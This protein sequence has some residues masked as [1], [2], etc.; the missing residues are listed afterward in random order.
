M[1]V[2]LRS[3]RDDAKAKRKRLNHIEPQ[4]W[5]TQAAQDSLLHG[6]FSPTFIFKKF[7]S[8]CI[9]LQIIQID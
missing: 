2:L 3:H 9:I 8:F 7:L 4:A 5:E 1:L 6:T